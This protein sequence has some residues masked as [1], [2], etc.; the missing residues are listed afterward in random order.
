MGFFSIPFLLWHCSK[1]YEMSPAS[2]AECVFVLMD[3]RLWCRQVKILH[4]IAPYNRDLYGCAENISFFNSLCFV[5][6][7]GRLYRIAHK[8][9]ERNKYMLTAFCNCKTLQPCYAV[10]ETDFDCQTRRMY[11]SN[12]A[13]GTLP[14]RTGRAK[15]NNGQVKKFKSIK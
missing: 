11:K 5:I 15:H 14:Y 8:I 3:G 12:N 9:Y 4:I 10:H 2:A 1:H 7:T 13:M 6:S